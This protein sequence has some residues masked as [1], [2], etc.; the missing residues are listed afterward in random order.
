MDVIEKWGVSVEEATDLAL[1]EMKLTRDDV[2]VTVLEEPSRGFFGIGSKL[3]KVKVER[4]APEAEPETESEPE[5][6]AP[7]KAGKA[8]RGPIGKEEVL[9]EELVTPEDRQSRKPRERRDRERNRD[10]KSSMNAAI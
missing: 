6:E 7:A 1:K 8:A 4:K 2:T 5:D 9:P 10:R 3:A